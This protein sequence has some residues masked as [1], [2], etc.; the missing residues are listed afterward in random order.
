MARTLVQPTPGRSRFPPGVGPVDYD[1]LDQ[2]I[3]EGKANDMTALAQ[4][5]V[6]WSG[7]GVVGNSTSTF[8]SYTTGGALP[9]TANGLTTFFNAIK[10]LISS[11]ITITVPQA[12]QT[13]D[14]VTGQ[15]VGSWGG[16]AQAPVAGTAAGA[17]QSASGAS[18][19]WITG[20]I[21]RRHL[22]V[23]RTFLVPL[24]SSAFNSSGVLSPAS[25]TT[26]ASAAA[27]L[28]SLQSARIWSRP[29]VANSHVGGSGVII[30]A[31]VKNLNAVLR[32][33]RQ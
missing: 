9:Q 32:S 24:A 33:R 19:E 22:L 21:L 7:A 6:A 27:G 13:Y 31:S 14:D 10:G 29:S 2:P 1:R 17:Q 11:G 4:I 25:V 20:V 18:V 28:A 23:G 12:G 3:T 15:L 8:Y 26:I 16:P 30:S 5:K